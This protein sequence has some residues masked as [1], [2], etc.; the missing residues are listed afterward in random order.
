MET[1]N[2]KNYVFAAPAVLSDGN[3]GFAP[4]PDLLTES[5]AIRFLRLDDNGCN[6]KRT[7]KYYRDSGRLIAIRVG[8]ENRYRLDDLRN[9]LTEKSQEKQRRSE[10]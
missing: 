7:L 3:G 8:R 2:D 5:E 4:C 6:S 1:V 10:R 9:F